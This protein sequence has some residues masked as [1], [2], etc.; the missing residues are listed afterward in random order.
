MGLIDENIEQFFEDMMD[1]GSEVE[2][3]EFEP[4]NFNILWESNE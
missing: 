3:M 2:M 4:P 1:E